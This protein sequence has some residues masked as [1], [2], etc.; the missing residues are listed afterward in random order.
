[1]T[2]QERKIAEVREAAA[3]FAAEREQERKRNEEI[4]NASLNNASAASS[5]MGD[6][7]DFKTPSSSPPPP[8]PL[9]LKVEQNWDRASPSATP[10]ATGPPPKGVPWNQSGAPVS[11][12]QPSQ[13]RQ[14]LNARLASGASPSQVNIPSSWPPP[15]SA[16]NNATNNKPVPPPPQVSKKTSEGG[17][18]TSL[19][20]GWSWK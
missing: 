20:K 15:P 6:E 5:V 19:L 9:A 1:M 4:R 2:E 16:T 12:A 18:A 8:P 14:P 11:P 13:G 10:V 7:T 17:L 3:R